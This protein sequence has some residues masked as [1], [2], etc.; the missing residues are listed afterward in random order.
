MD[1]LLA[2]LEAAKESAE[3]W[4][5]LYLALALTRDELDDTLAQP[6]EPRRDISPHLDPAPVRL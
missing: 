5:S 3:Y 4:R 1:T 2:E 6:H